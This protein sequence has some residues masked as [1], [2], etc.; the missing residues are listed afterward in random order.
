[1]NGFV[2][3]RQGLVDAMKA[4]AA[5]RARIGGRFVAVAA[6]T[7]AAEPELH[8]AEAQWA[9]GDGELVVVHRHRRRV[10][11]A[12]IRER[13]TG[14]IASVLRIALRRDLP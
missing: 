10:D 3:V 1:M 8:I 7:G 12:A 13:M 2:N 14:T 5:E 9:E 6:F 4:E 11:R